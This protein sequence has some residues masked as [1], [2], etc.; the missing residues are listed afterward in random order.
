M[1]GGREIYVEF[2]ALGNAVKATAIDPATG[3][4]ASVMGPSGAPRASLADA[5]T[6]KLKYVLEKKRGGE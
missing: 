1:A 4:E 2:V 6:R 3:I 5:A